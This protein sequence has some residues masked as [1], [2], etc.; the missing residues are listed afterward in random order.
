[1]QLRAPKPPWA[2]MWLSPCGQLGPFF[3]KKKKAESTNQNKPLTNGK[4]QN[5]SKF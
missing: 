1:M 2:L 3:L 5:D 4:N